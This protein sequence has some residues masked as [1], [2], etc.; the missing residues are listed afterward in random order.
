MTWGVQFLRD[1]SRSLVGSGRDTSSRSSLRTQL[2]PVSTSWPGLGKSQSLPHAQPQK[3]L[4]S[5]S[6]CLD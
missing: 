2:R 5:A 1:P 3:A 6:S 4:R